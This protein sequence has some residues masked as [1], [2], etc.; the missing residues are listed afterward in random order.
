MSKKV[1]NIRA[2]VYLFKVNNK[3]ARKTCET[4]PESTIKTPKQRQ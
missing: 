4:C 1:N 3:N 2:N